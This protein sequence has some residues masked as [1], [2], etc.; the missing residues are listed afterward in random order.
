MLGQKVQT[1]VVVT[2]NNATRLKGLLFKCIYIVYIILYIFLGMPGFNTLVHRGPFLQYGSGFAGFFAP[3]IKWLVPLIRGAAPAVQKQVVKIGKEALKSSAVREA[4]SQAQTH[5][6]KEGSNA[7]SR[8]LTGTAAVD[9]KKASSSEAAESKLIAAVDESIKT[10][11]PTVLPKSTV[12]SRVKNS[13]KL[14]TAP[15]AKKRPAATKNRRIY[16]KPK[17]PS[18]KKRKNRSMSLV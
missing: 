16:K 8:L 5:L 7:A 18:I 1:L 12:I 4:V 6:L 3:V 15:A 13:Y 9:G 11:N 14:S 10:N 2:L 17:L